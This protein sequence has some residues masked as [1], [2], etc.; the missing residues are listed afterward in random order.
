[1]DKKIKI[2]GIIKFRIY[3]SLFITLLLFISIYVAL[4]LIGGQIAYWWETP[5]SNTFFGILL[6]V[7]GC[8][9]LIIALFYKSSDR[10]Y[11]LNE[12]EFPKLVKIINEVADDLGVK[13]PSKIQLLP[14]S[15]IYVTGFFV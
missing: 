13:R 15:E 7:L 8:I 11:I 12:K 10:G 3:F 9:P 5:E 6:S 4:F 1:M 14:T 2:P